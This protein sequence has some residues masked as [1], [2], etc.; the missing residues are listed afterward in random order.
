LRL[1]GRQVDAHDRVDRIDQRQRIGAPFDG[2]A[3]DVRD[4]GDV[5]RELHDHRNRGDFLHPFDDLAGV[6]GH[7]TH[8]AAHAALAHPVRAA[9]V[10]LDPVGAGVFRLLH[11]LVPRFPLRFDHQRRDHGMLR[12]V[13]LDLGDFLEVFG[14]RPVADELDVVEAHHPVLPE[15]HGT[16]ARE[17]IDDRLADGLPDRAAPALVECF[18]DLAVGVRGGPGRQPEWIR[19]LDPREVGSD[20]SHKSLRSFTR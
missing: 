9:E 16:V 10:Q 12:V 1:E 5:G 17:D 13:T 18:G 2:R 6:I 20:I 15:V 4:I 7:L 19:G 14:D 11:H 8:R 3:R